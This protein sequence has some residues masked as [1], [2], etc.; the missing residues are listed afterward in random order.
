MEGLQR[1]A[2]SIDYIEKKLEAELPIEHVAAVA[3]MSKFHFQR[4]FHML[5]GV[6]VAEY[7]RKRRLTMV[8]QELIHSERR[9]IALHLNMGMKRQRHFQKHSVKYTE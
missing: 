8:A 7:I 4:M 1:M 3:C 9:V 5:T 6:N 2:A